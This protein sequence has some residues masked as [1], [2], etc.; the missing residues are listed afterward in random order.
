MYVYIY[1]V[2][3]ENRWLKM[4]IYIYTG[5]WYTCPSEKYESQL[6]WLHSHILWKIKKCLKPPTSI[7][8]RGFIFNYW[9]YHW[10]TRQKKN[11]FAKLKSSL[12]KRPM[13]GWFP[14]TGRFFQNQP[15]RGCHRHW[16]LIRDEYPLVNIQK[17]MEND[18][19]VRWFTQL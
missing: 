17:A 10:N 2:W 12:Q 7:I 14:L 19:L 13:W 8:S 9:G 5:W 11:T 15:T 4:D 1:D 16:W 6:G 3:W 18:N